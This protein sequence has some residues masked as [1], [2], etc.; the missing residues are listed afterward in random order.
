M[1]EETGIDILH[2]KLT[3]LSHKME[4]SSIYLKGSPSLG[5]VLFQSDQENG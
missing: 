1:M 3:P 2:Q 4:L 5:L